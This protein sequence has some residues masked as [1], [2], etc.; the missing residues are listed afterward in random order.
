MVNM[1]LIFILLFVNTV[2]ASPLYLEM[3]SIDLIDQQL[4]KCSKASEL[5]PLMFVEKDFEPGQYIHSIQ[6]INTSSKESAKSRKKYIDCINAILL[7]EEEEQMVQTGLDVY[8]EA[9]WSAMESYNRWLY[10]LDDKVPVKPSELSAFSEFYISKSNLYK[11]LERRTRELI[12]RHKKVEA[13]YSPLREFE[14]IYNSMFRLHFEF[15]QNLNPTLRKEI[16][17]TIRK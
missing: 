4:Q 13:N 12:R 15:Y 16:L 1:L 17:E 8:Y 10:S 6:K 5:P 14:S 3:T 9:F 11:L 2:S 7:S